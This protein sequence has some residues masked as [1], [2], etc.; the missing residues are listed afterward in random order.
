[1][2]LFEGNYE[3]S[4]SVQNTIYN[5]HG[6]RIRY[7]RYWSFQEIRKFENTN[8]ESQIPLFFLSFFLC[9]L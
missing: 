3:I 1:M 5:A 7:K 9:Y 2:Y 4:E 8:Y 6:N